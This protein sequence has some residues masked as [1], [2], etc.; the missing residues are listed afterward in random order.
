[1]VPLHPNPEAGPILAG[2]LRGLANVELGPPL[3]YPQF[4]ALERK[5]RFLI[6]DSGGVQEEAPALGKPV[7]VAR[8][9]TERPEALRTG[10]LALTGYDAAKLTAAAERFIG[11]PRRL[12]RFRPVFPYGDGK[13]SERIAA[14]IV[15]FLKDLA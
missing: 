13:A 9:K 12:A 11:D 3:G 8:E 15:E 4:C 2:A 5:C 10:H 7:L 6:S 1:V 14:R